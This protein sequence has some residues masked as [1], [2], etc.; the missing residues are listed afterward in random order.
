MMSITEH[1]SGTGEKMN[2]AESAESSEKAKQFLLTLMTL[3]EVSDLLK[4]LRLPRRRVSTVM[5][6]APRLQALV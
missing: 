2:H 4:K 1:R 3:R 6:G 5:E